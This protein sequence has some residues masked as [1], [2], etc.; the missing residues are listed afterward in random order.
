M[1]WPKRPSLR[2]RTR[3]A[4]PGPLILVALG[5]V[6]LIGAGVALASR[7]T[8]AA[9]RDSDTAFT[10]ST[11]AGQPAPAFTALDA[12]GQSYSVTPGDGRPKAILFYMGYG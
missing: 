6:A 8:G 11:H 3:K 9:L 2:S 7:S 5:I 4:S 12:Q 10:V 1:S